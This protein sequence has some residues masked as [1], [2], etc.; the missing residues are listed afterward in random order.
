MI[1]DRSSGRG[2]VVRTRRSFSPSAAAALAEI[3]RRLLD[4]LCTHR[5]VRQDQLCRLFPAIPERTL[6]YRTRRL[7]DLGLAGRSR[8]YR[9]QGSAPNHHWPTRRADCLIRGEPIPRGGERKQPNPIF[10]AHTAAL[11]ELYVAIITNARGAG[12]KRL[13]YQREGEA[14]ET[15]KDGVRERA[16]A[17][18]ATL[19]LLD[20]Q[21]RELWAFVEIDLG[22]MS[23]TR[24]RAKA[25]LYAAYASSDAWREGHPFL[26]ALLFLTTTDIRAAKFLKALARALSYGP[27]RHGRRAFVA[28]GAGIAWTPHQLLAEPC[29]ADLDGDTRLTLLDIL[30]AA[31][32]PHEQALA[33]QRERHGAKEEKRR[34]LREEPVA[35]REYLRHYEHALGS[36]FQAPGQPG[37]Q[38]IKLLLASPSAPLPGERGALRA[39]ARDLGEALTEPEQAVDP[40]GAEVLSEVALLI[41]D[42]RATQTKQV[43]A[44]AASHGEGPSL[45]RAWDQLREGG[46]LDPTVLDRLPQDAED[47]VAGRRE[48]HERRDFYLNW[49]EQ[50]ARQLARKAGPLGRLTH[51]PEDFYA[52]LDREHLKVCGRCEETIYPRARDSDG[53]TRPPACH[54]CHEAHGIKPYN[55]TLT[56][57]RESETFK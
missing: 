13:G 25:E 12:F 31:R 32:E 47:D 27:R 21:D 54:Y 10:L 11:T 1:E 42:Y 30:N 50:A 49:R 36:Y 16:L 37:V 34:H 8:P 39:I 33:Y 40:P 52:Q 24:L 20:E 22:T 23:H 44:L 6:R 26:P 43:R 46:L 5:V 29:P 4:V 56:A 51:R 35:M 38:A 2:H 53:F 48:Q 19:G 9:E 57:G 14:R 15:F 3:D 28:A 18:D 45:R 55:P 7:H 41:E 17:P